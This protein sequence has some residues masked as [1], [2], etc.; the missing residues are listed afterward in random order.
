[1]VP[2]I[3]KKALCIYVHTC[4][5]NRTHKYQ[6]MDR[7]GIWRNEQTGA[8]LRR[9]IFPLHTL[10]LFEFFTMGAY[11]HNTCVTLQNKKKCSIK[12]LSW[13]EQILPSPGPPARPVMWDRETQGNEMGRGNQ[14]CKACQRE[15]RQRWN[16]P[17]P[18]TGLTCQTSC[19]NVHLP[20]QLQRIHW[21]KCQGKD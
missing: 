4:F 3:L 13:T 20:K 19:S 5:W 2:F 16:L 17:P 7:Y 9:R 18:H 15:T 12:S 1:M 8:K 11:L 6:S 21:S 10:A 14:E